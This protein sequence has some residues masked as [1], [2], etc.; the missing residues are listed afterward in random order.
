MGVLS[1]FF[2]RKE[3][4]KLPPAPTGYY[5]TLT[6]PA[7]HFVQW[8]GSLYDHPLTRAAI[9]RFAVA[10]SKAKPEFVGS[11]WC[12]PQVRKLFE[13][14]PNDLMTWPA[15]LAKAAT[16][17]EMDTTVFIVPGLDR[18]LNTVALFPLKP[19]Y[20]EV[21]DIDGEPWFVFHMLTGEVMAIEVARVAV[22]SKFQYIS[23]F[24]GEGNDVMDP[25]LALMDAQRQ[26]EMQAI[27]NGARIRFIGRVN[28]MTHG[29]DLKQKREA[30][31]VDN[32][33]AANRTGLMLYDNT[34][35]EI[36]QI[37]EQRFIIDEA[38]MERV[39]K[40]I[41]Y[42]FGINESILTNSYDE[43]QWGAWYEGRVEPFLIA[44]SEAL[45]K[46]LFT[47][48]EVISGNRVMFSSSRL[49]YA[50]NR[51][52]LEIISK[53]G[54]MGVFTVNECRD[55]MQ[56]PPMVGGDARIVRGEYYLIDDENNIIAE[57][58]GHHGT[59][60][61][62]WGES[63]WGNSSWG[64]SSWDDLDEPDDD[65]DDDD[66]SSKRKRKA[67]RDGDGDGVIG[68]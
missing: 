64:D 5:Q 3:Q 38:E 54:G 40:P 27:Q 57:S 17:Y 13:S 53:I 8:S 67:K 65:D 36:K 41:Y 55:I 19:S 43:D 26:A 1:R 44:L 18:D 37:D 29:D 49:Q 23:D 62:G 32:L 4:Q 22:I 46:A 10:C 16:I 60:S 15:F 50:S 28:G 42:Y 51:T 6:E 2:P 68:E 35:Q 7:P 63:S 14:W 24:F 9:E 52:K 34:F 11:K 20:T 30:F 61:S 21:M 39:T 45:T 58:G 66:S 33:S 31:Y 56:Q 25:T 47:Q 12:K 59:S 48:R